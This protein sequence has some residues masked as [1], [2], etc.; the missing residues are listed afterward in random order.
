MPPYEAASAA[1]GRA[2]QLWVCWWLAVGLIV[3]GYPYGLA[4]GSAATWLSPPS[5]WA[6]ARL[7][8]R[9][10]TQLTGCDW[11]GA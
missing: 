5:V 3:L 7:R 9:R 8:W 2:Q 10:F 6:M 11:P 4:L 1:A